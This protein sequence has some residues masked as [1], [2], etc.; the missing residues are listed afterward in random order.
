[1]YGVKGPANLTATPETGKGNTEYR[2]AFG[3]AVF[4]PPHAGPHCPLPVSGGPVCYH[5][6]FLFTPY[7]F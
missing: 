7:I 3:K 6:P 1:M 4:L 2:L 5:R